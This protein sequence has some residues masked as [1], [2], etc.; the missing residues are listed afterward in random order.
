MSAFW[1]FSD[2][3]VKYTIVNVQVI[4]LRNFNFSH[5]FTSKMASETEP[6][7]SLLLRKHNVFETA[8]VTSGFRIPDVTQAIETLHA[9]TFASQ[10]KK[11]L[12]QH[13]LRLRENGEVF[14]KTVF[15][16]VTREWRRPSCLSWLPAGGNSRKH[17][18]YLLYKN[19]PLMMTS[20]MRLSSSR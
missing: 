13:L 2:F 8:C 10:K 7:K 1:L 6:W 12:P 18:I 5:T 11:F 14:E 16:F 17:G 19:I 9:K 4:E 15:L 20:S 3:L